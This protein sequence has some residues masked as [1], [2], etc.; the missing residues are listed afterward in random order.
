M[1]PSKSYPI[2]LTRLKQR[3]Q[4]N[5]DRKIGLVGIVLCRPEL[6]MVREEIIPSLDYFNRVSGSNVDFFFAGFDGDPVSN[7]DSSKVK[8]GISSR[9]KWHF[10]DEEFD[11]FA[12]DLFTQSG[13]RYAQ[14]KQQEAWRGLKLVDAE[15]LAG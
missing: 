6:K 9:S 13:Q 2:L 5:P 8:T 7:P 12:Q 11:R 14:N 1:H 4:E 15:V 10:D 3:F